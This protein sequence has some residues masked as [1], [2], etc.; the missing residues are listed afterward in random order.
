MKRSCK[1][2]LGCIAWT[3]LALGGC[4]TGGTDNKQALIGT[5][6][7]SLG[8]GGTIT[9]SPDGT[10]VMAVQGGKLTIPCRYTW[11]DDTHMRIEETRT[12]LNPRHPMVPVVAEVKFSGNRLSVTPTEVRQGPALEYEKVE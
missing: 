5:W 3:V 7:T 12:N 6:R 9:D 8:H 1:W 10:A 11:I 4:G 2:I